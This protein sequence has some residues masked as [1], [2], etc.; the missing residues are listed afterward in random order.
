MV[1][2][3]LREIGR[4]PAA[5]NSMLDF[6][7]GCGRFLRT[8]ADDRPAGLKL[9]GSDFD[10]EAIGWCRKHL[11]F[12]D[13]QVNGELPPLRYED[14]SFDVVVCTSLFTHLD[15]AHHEAWIPELARVLK[16]GGVA[17]VT[18]RG[19]ELFEQLMPGDQRL[20]DLKRD[21]FLLD[22]SI[23]QKT[24]LPEWYQD[25]FTTEDF[26]REHWGG[27]FRW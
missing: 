21:G 24:V 16:P 20:E 22:N 12:A 27:H 5:V 8:Y 1:D 9:Y 17:L 2:E 23:T 6:A 25:A 11:R 3:V 10:A 19:P 7:C 26:V 15:R 14:G 13:F 18:F 4:D